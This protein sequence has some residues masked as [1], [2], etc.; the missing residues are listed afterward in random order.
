MHWHKKLLLALACANSHDS[1]WFSI[2]KVP[3]QLETISSSET[4]VLGFFKLGS[5]TILEHDDAWVYFRYRFMWLLRER[6]WVDEGAAIRAEA[7]SC[8][9]KVVILVLHMN[10]KLA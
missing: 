2:S 1:L 4:G 8:T 6:I 3:C 9:W 10:A 7:M 5:T